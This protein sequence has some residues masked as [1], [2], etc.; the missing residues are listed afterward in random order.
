MLEAGP[1]QLTAPVLPNV[2]AARGN[3]AGG[4]CSKKLGAWLHQHLLTGITR[5]PSEMT[6]GRLILMEWMRVFKC[7]Y[8]FSGLT[9]LT[10][11]SPS[12]NCWESMCCPNMI[13][14][15]EFSQVSGFA[16]PRASPGQRVQDL[17]LEVGGTAHH[18]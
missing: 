2:C 4:K 13:S 9:V 11:S 15:E 6:I 3:R 14:M 12:Y 10:G 1:A 8:S 7:V 5:T 17:C 16:W 18:K